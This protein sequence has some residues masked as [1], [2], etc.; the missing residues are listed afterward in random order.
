MAPLWSSWSSDGLH[1]G[2]FTGALPRGR[3]L[4]AAG[5]DHDPVVVAGVV[6][7]RLN[8][9]VLAGLLEA[10]VQLAEV[11]GL[12]RRELVLRHAGPKAK[13]L[14]LGAVDRAQRERQRLLAA[15]ADHPHVARAL[16]RGGRRERAGLRHLPAGGGRDRGVRSGVGPVGGALQVRQGERRHREQGGHEGSGEQRQPRRTGGWSS[17]SCPSRRLSLLRVPFPQPAGD[18]NT[19]NRRARRFKTGPHNRSEA[20]QV[21]RIKCRRSDRPR[22]FDNKDDRSRIRP[23]LGRV[24]SHRTL[25]R[26][27]AL[28]FRSRVRPVDLAGG[29]A[30]RQAFGLDRPRHL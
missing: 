13:A 25:S 2:S 28:G 29:Q 1:A 18:S 5:H 12:L 10:L 26:G 15:L 27:S 14:G 17:C 6:D 4:V 9:A 21:V 7:R 19:G 23:G 11:A 3:L 20:G 22:W 8:R 30:S 24:G 16:A